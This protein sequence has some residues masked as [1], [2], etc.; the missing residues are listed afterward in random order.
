MTKEHLDSLIKYATSERFADEILQAKKEYQKHAGELFEDDKSYEN[1][2]NA[3]LEWYTFDRPLSDQI[4]PLEKFIEENRNILPAEQMAIYDGFLNNIHGIFILK[5]IK[6]DQV[7]IYNL[8]DDNNYDVIEQDGN[9]F[10]HKKDVTYGYWPTRYNCFNYD[11]NCR[12]FNFFT[13]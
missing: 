9:I 8:F 10:F 4:V 6:D 2:M 3:F 12:F 13:V 1:R 11:T 5:K 7:V